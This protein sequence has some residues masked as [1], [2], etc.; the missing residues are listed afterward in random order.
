[1]RDLAGIDIPAE[2]I[3]SQTE[4]GRPK[5][6]VLARLEATHPDS[7]RLAFVEDKLATLEKV[8]SSLSARI[9]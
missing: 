2:R 6:E 7:P 1:M 4:S 8:F 3:F 5:Y 9:V